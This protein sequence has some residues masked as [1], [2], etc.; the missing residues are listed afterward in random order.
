MLTL[1]CRE[2]DFAWL[3]PRSKRT[4]HIITRVSTGHMMEGKHDIVVYPSGEMNPMFFV[5]GSNIIKT[6]KAIPGSD[7]GY[8]MFRYH[9]Q[10]PWLDCPEGSWRKMLSSQ[11]PVKAIDYHW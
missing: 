9:C 4:E 1:R 6:N 3:Y 8:E 2:P 7:N 11:P 5:Q 10:P